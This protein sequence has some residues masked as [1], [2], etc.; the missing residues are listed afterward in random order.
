MVE[1]FWGLRLII[2][3]GLGFVM[4]K[5][6]WGFGVYRILAQE[7]ILQGLSASWGFG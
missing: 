5:G 3:Q 7:R 4:V 2:Y 6:F 1:G